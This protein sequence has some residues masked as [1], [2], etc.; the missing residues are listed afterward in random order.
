MREREVLSIIHQAKKEKWEEL[1]LSGND[2]ISI[3]AD[4]GKLSDLK[5]LILGVL[6][7][8]VIN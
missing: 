4:I 6:T 5:R 3:P 7:F 8:M 2:L 1:D